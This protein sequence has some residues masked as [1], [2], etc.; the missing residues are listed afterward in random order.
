MLGDRI[1]RDIATISDEER[2]LFVNAIRKLNDPT[3]AFV[4]GNNLGH[5][6][7]MPAPASMAKE[8]AGG[9]MDDAANGFGLRSRLRTKW[10]AWAY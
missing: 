4:Y 5:E 9:M 6:V 10:G 3:S 8:R 2:T 7:P 1:R